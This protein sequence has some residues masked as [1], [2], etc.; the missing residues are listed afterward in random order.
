[1]KMQKSGIFAEEKKKIAEEFKKQFA[2]LEEYIEKYITFA[3]PTL[4][5]K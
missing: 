3:I 5:K 1:M 4:H 2:C